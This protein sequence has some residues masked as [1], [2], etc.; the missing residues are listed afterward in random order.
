MDPIANMIVTIKNGYLAR[1]DEVIMPF[2]KFRF[3]VAKVLE[4]SGF[5]TKVSKSENTVKVELLYTE[6]NKPRITE[7]KKISKQG[8]RIYTKS[9]NI[10]PVKGGRGITIISTSQGVMTQR[11]AQKK[12]LGGEVICRVW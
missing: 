6:G 9:K 5:V 10:R 7:I 11:E 3:E 4:K 2:S 12:N 8:L 1:K